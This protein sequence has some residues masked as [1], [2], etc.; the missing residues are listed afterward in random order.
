M[1]FVNLRDLEFHRLQIA[2]DA[3]RLQPRVLKFAGYEPR[4]AEM[5]WRPR[6][7]AFHIVVG[8][9]LDMRPPAVAFLRKIGFGEI[10]RRKQRR[11]GG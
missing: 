8:Q 2:V 4:R 10:G 5:T 11:N 9:D 3:R 1:L 7:A 6:V